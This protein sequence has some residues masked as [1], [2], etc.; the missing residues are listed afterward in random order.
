MHVVERVGDA[1]LEVAAERES[2][3]DRRGQGAAGAVQRAGADAGS[4]IATGAVGRHQHVGDR[5]P[6][7]M[8]T[9]DQ[10]GP[11]AEAEQRRAGALHGE[12][13]VHGEPGEDRGLVEVGRHQR[14]ERQQHLTEHRFGVGGEQ[15]L[16]RR[17]DHDRIDHQRAPSGGADRPTHLA[18]QRRIGE[19]AGLHGIGRKVLRQR[20][21]LGRHHRGRHGLDCADAERILRGE[22]DDG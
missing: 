16:P 17:A 5:V 15:P 9:L 6:A 12:D 3:R 14:G 7:H 20:G 21:E 13:V 11:R 1:G 18:D 22:R 10:D 8:P 2:G 19:H 4:L